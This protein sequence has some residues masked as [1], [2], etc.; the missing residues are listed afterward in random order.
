[1]HA[2]PLC[3]AV[4]AILAASPARPPDPAAVALNR[5]LTIMVMI[6][7]RH[8]QRPIPD[9]AAETEITRHLREAGF[10]M[11]D[12]SQS[13]KVLSR[14]V[15]RL[16]RREPKALAAITELARS[17]GAD[18]IVV[19]EAFSEALPGRSAT[20]KIVCSARVEVRAIDTRTAEIVFAHAERCTGADPAE[21]VA[22]KSALQRAAGLLAPRLVS[23]FNRRA[24]G[25]PIVEVRVSV[26]NSFTEASDF[27]SAVREVPG[28]AALRERSFTEGVLTLEVE[29]AGKTSGDLA[30]ALEAMSK[31]RVS[32]KNINGS[33]IDAHIKRGPMPK[34]RR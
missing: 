23:A 15:D 11:K 27:Q 14:D 9:P 31:F 29:L 21:S 32:V 3:L 16:R 33:S 34:A 7:E 10:T 18:Y 26:F 22:S 1:M 4:A 25:P 2:S 5:R 30:R 19:G 24:Q 28:V 12:E 20:G 13:L 6:P 17:E 8:I